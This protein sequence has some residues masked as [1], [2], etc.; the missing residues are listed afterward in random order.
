MR[1]I[2]VSLALAAVGCAADVW[3]QKKPLVDIPSLGFQEIEAPPTGNA[4]D[5]VAKHALDCPMKVRMERRVLKIEPDVDI[6]ERAAVRSASGRVQYEGTNRGE[7]GGTL[8]AIFAD[9]TRRELLRKNVVSIM[10]SGDALLVFTGLSHLMTNHGHVH[11]IVNPGHAPSLRLVTLLPDAPLAVVHDTSKT[12]IDR[13]FLIGGFSLTSLTVDR[14][15]DDLETQIWKELWAGKSPRS[16]VF[17]KNHLVIGSF[18][19]VA[20]VDLDDM[21]LRYFAPKPGVFKKRRIARPGSSDHYE[22]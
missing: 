22:C 21:S 13:F 20:I 1:A 6:F 19:G 8:T 2:A 15:D 14:E 18:S 17:V 9:G 10:P 4:R 3:A 11:R 7:W 5:W 16:A 12:R